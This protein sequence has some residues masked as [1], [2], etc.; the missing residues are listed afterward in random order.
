MT[1]L[2]GE[3]LAAPRLAPRKRDLGFAVPISMALHGAVIAAIAM[4]WQLGTG[5]SA[6]MPMDV[7]IVMEP[8]MAEEAP[9]V[10][11]AR[12]PEI[13]EQIPDAVPPPPVE[14][15][16]FQP[17]EPPVELLQEPPPP[18]DLPEPEQ[19]PPAVTETAFVMPAPPPPPPP[20][21]RKPVKKETAK[22]QPPKVQPVQSPPAQEPTQ[23]AALAPAAAPAAETGSPAPATA[24]QPDKNAAAGPTASFRG[25]PL[26]TDPSFRE[27]PRKPTYPRR[28]VD[29]EQ[30]G[31]VVVRALVDTSGNPATVE[32]W[33]SSGFPLLDRAAQEAVRK[34]RFRP[35][36]L[37]SRPTEAWVQ[38][39]VHFNLR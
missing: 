21:V 4:G 8:A 20:P 24:P 27:P 16:E 32:V 12:A 14:T 17:E 2:V 15:A 13:A 22:P 25:L 29:L 9:E 26:V 11:A 35:A 34:W 30:K 23:L 39:A 31:T 6:E 36:T 19:L 18:I 33:T 7:V 10:Q 3:P 5:A 37:N 28:A 1:L 38:V